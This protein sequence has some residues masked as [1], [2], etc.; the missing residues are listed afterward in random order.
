MNIFARILRRYY[1]PTPRKGQIWESCIGLPEVEVFG[2]QGQGKFVVFA[3]VTS[4]RVT[5]QTLKAF[6]FAYRPVD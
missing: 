2:I 6:R 5:V 4:H 1:G 3:P